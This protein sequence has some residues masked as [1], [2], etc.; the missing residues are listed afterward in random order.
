MA[1]RL[2]QI[3]LPVETLDHL[4][5]VA[6]QQQRTVDALVRELILQ[7]L[8]ALP[9]LPETIETELAA[10]AHLSDEALRLLMDG[11]LHGGKV[12][13]RRTFAGAF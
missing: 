3:E 9:A 7:E 11:I 12:L 4:A 2:L 13:W 10:F 6:R 8:P 5:Q 1:S